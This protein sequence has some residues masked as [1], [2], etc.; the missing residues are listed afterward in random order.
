MKNIEA[1]PLN[2]EN[3]KDLFSLIYVVSSHNKIIDDSLYSSYNSKSSKLII[4][5]DNKNDRKI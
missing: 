3:F 1:L 2:K 5:K 4:R